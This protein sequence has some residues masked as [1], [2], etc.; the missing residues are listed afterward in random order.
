MM[1]AGEIEAVQAVAAS[2][3]PVMGDRVQRDVPI[4]PL[5]SFRV[6]GRAAL[7]VEAGDEGDLGTVASALS[8]AKVPLLVLGKGS[9]VL[10][11]DAGFP[12]VVLML[13]KGFEWVRGEGSLVDAGGN[14]PFPR[15]ANWAARRSLTGLEFSVAIPA[16]VG[17]AVRMNAGAYGSSVADVLH[18]ARIFRI[19]RGDAV[20][21][22]PDELGMGYRTTSIGDREVVCSAAF[23]LG[24]GD[25]AVIRETM[26]AHRDHRAR[27]Q[28]ADAPNAGSMFRNP[29]G[30]SAGAVIEQAGLKGSRVGG[31]EVSAKHANFFLANP[32]ARAQDVYDLMV[33]VQR[34]VEDRSGVL[35][36]PEVRV[37]GEFRDGGRLRWE[38]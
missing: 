33:E 4:A 23:R 1:A 12:G 18:A 22:T 7:L 21:L 8:R 11:S 3:E 28:P 38:R 34:G 35:L 27:T 5:T 14:T 30:S 10:V 25:P 16:T 15:V 2:L 37:V 20:E 36:V 31:A 13:G 26:S 32:G 17:G 6:G 24:E 19:D 9:N 29:E